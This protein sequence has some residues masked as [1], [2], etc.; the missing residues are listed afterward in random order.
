[1]VGSSKG[2]AVAAQAEEPAVPVAD[3][4]DAGEE[5]KRRMGAAVLV[6]IGAVLVGLR[7]R[8]ACACGLADIQWRT[9]AA[10]DFHRRPL[11]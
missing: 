11:W 8:R 3:A 9:I 2:K 10:K 1:M 4:L 5:L 6:T 7:N